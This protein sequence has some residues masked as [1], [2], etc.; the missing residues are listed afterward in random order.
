MNTYI[1]SL[2]IT[3]VV[4]YIIVYY[5]NNYGTEEQKNKLNYPNNKIYLFCFV[6]LFIFGLFYLYNSNKNLNLGTATAPTATAPTATTPTATVN[7][8]TIG[9][10]STNIDKSSLKSFEAD[11]INSIKDQEVD[12]GDVPF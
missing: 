4:F 3:I 10:R 9:G 1:Y 12:V 2:G 8:D 11:F 6:G 7:T 5:I